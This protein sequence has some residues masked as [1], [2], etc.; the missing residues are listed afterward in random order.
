MTC[1]AIDT[2]LSQS[3]DSDSFTSGNWGMG[4]G[5]ILLWDVTGQKSEPLSVAP[6]G[7]RAKERLGIQVI[8]GLR[9]ASG[10]RMVGTGTHLSP[11]ETGLALMER[12]LLNGRVGYRCQHPA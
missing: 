10:L 1:N 2:L 6:E 9:M 4:G 5:D 12:H 3:Q 7:S 8:S 11:S